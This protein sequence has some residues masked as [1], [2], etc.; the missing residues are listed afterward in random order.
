MYTLTVV[1]FKELDAPVEHRLCANV[2][3]TLCMGVKLGL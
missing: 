1:D 2:K 3:I